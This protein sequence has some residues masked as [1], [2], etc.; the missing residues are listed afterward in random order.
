M[1]PEMALEAKMTKMKLSYFGHVM[2]TQ[3]SLEKKIRLGKIASRRKRGRPNI[4]W[5]DP[6]K[7]PQT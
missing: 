6:I 5:T 4:R 2:R 7:E 3:G 1:K